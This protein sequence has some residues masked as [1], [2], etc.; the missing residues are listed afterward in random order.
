MFL[1]SPF[2]L[3]FLW[4]IWSQPCLPSCSCCFSPPYHISIVFEVTTGIRAGSFFLPGCLSFHYILLQSWGFV[5]AFR[6]SH[7]L[8]SNSRS[9]YLTFHYYGYLTLRFHQKSSI[10]LG[11][12]TWLFSLI[13]KIPADRCFQC[14]NKWMQINS[15]WD[16]RM[17]R[18]R[19][20]FPRKGALVEHENSIS[21]INFICY[22]R[23]KENAGQKGNENFPPV[24]NIVEVA[25]KKVSNLSCVKKGKSRCCVALNFPTQWI[26]IRHLRKV[27]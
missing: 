21:I 8:N 15:R 10:W 17:I 6:T 23:Q 9:N 22:E 26:P 5:K 20:R 27:R 19:A 25:R 2:Q 16:V 11:H 18:G 12:V 24:K 3:V 14:P 7:E 4:F 1:N 13:T